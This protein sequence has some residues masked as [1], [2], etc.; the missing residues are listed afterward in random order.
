MYNKQWLK[1][2]IKLWPIFQVG[3]FDIQE[4]FLSSFRYEFIITQYSDTVLGDFHYI[5][6]MLNHLI[7]Q[8]MTLLPLL[9]MKKKSCN[10]SL[11]PICIL[12]CF[13]MNVIF[14]YVSVT[15]IQIK[16]EQHFQRKPMFL[17]G[18]VTLKVKSRSPKRKIRLFAM[19]Q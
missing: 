10:T 13:C 8:Q 5:S 19:S 14:A 17:I 6:L 1:C 11:N 9:T 18:A 12:T 15:V 7:T 2:R 4:M 3:Y 16:Q